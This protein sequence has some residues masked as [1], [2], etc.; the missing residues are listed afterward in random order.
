[1]ETLAIVAQY[2]PVTRTEIE[3][4]RGA[5]LSQATIDLLLEAGLIAPRGTKN[6]PGGPTLWVTA[7]AFLAH[8][9]LGSLRDVPAAAG[10]SCRSGP[11]PAEG[12]SGAIAGRRAARG[13]TNAV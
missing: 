4:I 9:G 7:P 2:Q 10:W 3:D 5:A 6:V 8:F 12:D 11:T 13:R 1:M